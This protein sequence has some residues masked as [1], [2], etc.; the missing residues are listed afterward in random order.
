MESGVI[1][2]I[3]PQASNS[4]PR[5]DSNSS[6]V[7]P[8]K[9]YTTTRQSSRY[10]VVVPVT[11]NQQRETVLSVVPDAFAKVSQGRTVMQVGV[12]S[13]QN[14]ASDMVQILNSRGLR[15]IIKRLN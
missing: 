15:A 4:T 11:N 7:V 13:T 8:S 10:R 6:V 2:F 3:A 12:F 1:E 14:K 5:T 9:P